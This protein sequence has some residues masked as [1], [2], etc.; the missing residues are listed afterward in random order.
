MTENCFFCGLLRALIFC[1]LLLFNKLLI[2]DA[3]NATFQVADITR[4]LPSV[5][6]ICEKGDLEVV[7][8]QDAAFI[9]DKQKRI[10]AK[11]PRRNGLYVSTMDVKNPRHP[12]FTRQA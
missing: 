2:E 11:F 5:T 3:L 1:C 8:R 10:V 6:K 4:P 9:L 7:C 12:G